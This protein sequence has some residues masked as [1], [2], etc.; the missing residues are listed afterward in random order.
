MLLTCIFERPWKPL[1]ESLEAHLWF[2]NILDNL[3]G[4]KD[5]EPVPS[6]FNLGP[7]GLGGCVSPACLFW[8]AL[9]C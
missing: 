7:A 8:F 5:P 6:L 2:L 4:V 9:K 3:F 1:C